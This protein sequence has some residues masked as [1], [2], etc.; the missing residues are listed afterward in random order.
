MVPAIVSQY[1]RNLGFP[2]LL[3]PELPIIDYRGI[4]VYQSA[5]KRPFL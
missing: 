4:S 2:I 1:A 5:A 3:R